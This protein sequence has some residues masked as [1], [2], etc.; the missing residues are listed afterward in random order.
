M[1]GAILDANEQAVAAYGYSIDE[2]KT[3]RIA[4]LRSSD[5]QHLLSVQMQTAF[6]KASFSRQSTGKRMA[7]VSLSK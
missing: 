4:D 6:E 1:D 7:P 5:S 3:L 2:L